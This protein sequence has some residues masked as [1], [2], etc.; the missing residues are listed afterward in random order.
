MALNNRLLLLLSL[1]AFCSL[2]SMLQ[3]SSAEESV[4]TTHRARHNQPRTPFAEDF[5]SPAPPPVALDDL[6]GLEGMTVLRK[7]VQAQRA[8]IAEM[9]K[10]LRDQ[11]TGGTG[12]AGAGAPALV[13]PSPWSVDGEQAKTGAGLLLFAY[14]GKK[15]LSHFLREAQYAADSFREHNPNIAIAIVSN[16]ASVDRRVFSTHI[17]PRADLL[18]AGEN[19]QKRSDQA[20]A[21]LSAAHRLRPPAL[22][23]PRRNRPRAWLHCQ[24][25][26]KHTWLREGCARA[27]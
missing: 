23:A 4:L 16:N 1:F 9:R 24:S 19:E 15:T 20:S 11:H 2:L 10:R 21:A 12:G 26:H 6:D 18:F 5:S 8:T 14:G 3:S 17:V 27:A 13:A 7:T 22:T 25:M